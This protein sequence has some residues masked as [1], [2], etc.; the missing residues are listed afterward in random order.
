MKRTRLLAAGAV[1]SLVSA[2]GL[3]ALGAAPASAALASPTPAS[4]AL[5]S[6]ADATPDILSTGCIV[7]YVCFFA[8]ANY[9]PSGGS[10]E[11]LNYS[12]TH[13]NWA[14]QNDPA[15]VCGG[16]VTHTW[17]DCASSL[18][19]HMQSI[20]YVWSDAHCAGSQLEI[21]PS[22]EIFNLGAEYNMNDKISSD[23]LSN[24]QPGC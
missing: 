19:S 3:A 21:H 5:A 17:N 13:V 10:K 14:T 20:M 1:L 7:G 2:L 22:E 16:I 9:S 6:P 24:S 8:D 23:T 18:Q 4:P 12:A 11:V 15:D